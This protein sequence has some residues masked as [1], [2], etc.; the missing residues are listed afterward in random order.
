M[1]LRFEVLSW[2]VT[3]NVPVVPSWVSVIG[4]IYE[5][6]VLLSCHRALSTPASARVVVWL[7][8]AEMLPNRRKLETLENI[9]AV[10]IRITA[11]KIIAIIKTWP[12]TLV[13]MWSF[14]IF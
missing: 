5:P 10:I 2:M 8:W 3:I 13:N 14:F 12:L 11:K 6:A 9:V 7:A 4:G 1:V